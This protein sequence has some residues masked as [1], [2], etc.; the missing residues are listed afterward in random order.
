MSSLLLFPVFEFTTYHCCYVFANVCTYVNRIN[1]GRRSVLKVVRVHFPPL[2]S[3]P[4][5][6]LPSLPLPFPLRP[7]QTQLG[8][9][10]SAVSSPSEVRGSR[11]R[12]LGAFRA[13]NR[14]WWQ[15][16][17]MSHHS[18]IIDRLFIDIDKRLCSLCFITVL[19][20]FCEGPNNGL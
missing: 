17:D 7:P 9:L 15:Q 10:G 2:P 4:F 19:Q 8:G 12:I 6:P 14:V 13:Q 18:L 5:F 20:T 16:C 1:H 3:F 11:K